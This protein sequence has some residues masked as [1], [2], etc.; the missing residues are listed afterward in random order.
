MPV[1]PLS[2]LAAAGFALVG[3]MGLAGDAPRHQATAVLYCTGCLCDEDRPEMATPGDWRPSGRMGDHITLRFHP[4]DPAQ[5]AS[6]CRSVPR[7]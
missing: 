5:T 2:T 7:G 3:A 1:S 6:A 4:R